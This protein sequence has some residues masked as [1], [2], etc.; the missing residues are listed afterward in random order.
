MRLFPNQQEER[1]IPSGGRVTAV[2]TEIRNTVSRDQRMPCQKQSSGMGMANAE[3]W[4]GQ[5]AAK[6]TSEPKQRVFRWFL[7]HHRLPHGAS[8]ATDQFGNFKLSPSLTVAQPGDWEGEAQ[9]Q[10]KRLICHSLHSIP[11]A[12]ALGQVLCWAPEESSNEQRQ[13]RGLREPKT[14]PRE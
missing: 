2:T 1:G 6:P 10:R 5:L 3:W 13:P 4:W 14:Q 7:Q 12:P 8:S 9:L 11:W